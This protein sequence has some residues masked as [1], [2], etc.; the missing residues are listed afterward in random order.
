MS[1]PPAWH[2]PVIITTPHSTSPLPQTLGPDISQRR[3]YLCCNCF[4]PDLRNNYGNFAAI[5]F[6]SLYHLVL[7]PNELSVIQLLHIDVSKVI[8]YI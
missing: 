6:S 1:M 5:T 4:L 7:G 2:P 8:Y 3:I